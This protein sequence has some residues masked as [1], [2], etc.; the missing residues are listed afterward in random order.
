[1]AI[2][3]GGKK[4]GGRERDCLLNWRDAKRDS[5][6]KRA[7][8]PASLPHS[9]YCCQLMQT[10]WEILHFFYL[11]QVNQTLGDIRRQATMANVML[12]AAEEK[13]PDVLVLFK[14]TYYRFLEDFVNFYCFIAPSS[15]SGNPRVLAPPSP[16]PKPQTSSSSPSGTTTPSW[17]TSSCT[18]PTWRTPWG[19]RR[20]TTRWE[21]ASFWR[22]LCLGTARKVS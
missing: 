4:K 12:E 5:T 10:L 8:A 15:P 18:T 20:G 21:A 1:M 13:T 22:L 6:Y 19:S 7:S 3:R 16:T 11:R 14:V 17:R 2:R 9:S